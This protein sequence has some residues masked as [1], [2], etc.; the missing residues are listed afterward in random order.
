[1]NLIEDKIYRLVATTKMEQLRYSAEFIKIN[2]NY[3]QD[4]MINIF[5][6]YHGIEY[7]IKKYYWIMECYDNNEIY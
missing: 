5:N 6:I 7:S 3:K 4:S 1:M 2:K